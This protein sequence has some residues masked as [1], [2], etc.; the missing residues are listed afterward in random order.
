M[1]QRPVKGGPF[2]AKAAQQH[3]FTG[4]FRDGFLHL[5]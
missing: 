4:L 1:E 3:R 2:S 5:R